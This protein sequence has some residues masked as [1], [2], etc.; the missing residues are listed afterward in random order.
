MTNTWSVILEKMVKLKQNTDSVHLECTGIKKKLN[1]E[2]LRKYSV[3]KVKKILVFDSSLPLIIYHFNTASY[4]WGNTVSICKT[5]S[6]NHFSLSLDKCSIPSIVSYPFGNMENCKA[7]WVCSHG[8]SVPMCCPEGQGYVPF[9]GCVPQSNCKDIC[10]L[11]KKEECNKRMT[12][13]ELDKYEEF[14]YGY[15]WVKKCCKPGHIFDSDSCQCIPLH[16]GKGYEMDNDK[17]KGIFHILYSKM[18][19]V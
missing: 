6:F 12:W 16:N 10:P 17:Q 18:C 9:K 4:T 7:H 11:E 13:D 1:V 2:R 5:I 19:F 8:K 15:G 3:Q 14:F